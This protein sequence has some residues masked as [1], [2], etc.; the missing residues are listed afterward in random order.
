MRKAAPVLVLMLF[1][2]II[3]SCNEISSKKPVLTGKN[4]SKMK[5]SEKYWAVEDKKGES[6]EF[7]FVLD[8]TASKKKE[9]TIEIR[10][11]KK[12]ERPFKL[13]LKKIGSKRYIFQFEYWEKNEKG[14]SFFIA[15]KI[16]NDRFLVLPYTKEA[17]KKAQNH[18]MLSSF[19]EHIKI[20]GSS[21]I[22]SAYAADNHKKEII[23]FMKSLDA[24]TD[25]KREDAL[26]FRGTNNESEFESLIDTLEK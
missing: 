9:W 26:I 1:I 23:G 24:E 18:P 25:F 5:I 22:F 7:G 17:I 6:G 13:R 16:K 12:N 4:S 8:D 20:T 14:Y 15:Q 3:L 21:V 11:D 10:P 2:T 19:Q